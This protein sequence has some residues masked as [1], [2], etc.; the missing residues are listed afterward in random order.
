MSE[1]TYSFFWLVL[2]LCVFFYT[3]FSIYMCLNLKWLNIGNIYLNLFFIHSGNVFCLMHGDHW[4]V[5]WFLIY[6]WD[7]IYHICYTFLFVTFFFFFVF[8]SFSAFCCFNWEFY[9]IPFS[10]LFSLWITL[11]FLNLFSG[12]LEFA[13][14]IYN[15]HKTTFQFF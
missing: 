7:N 8:Y 4:C 9:I 13:I 12:I 14:Y 11:P 5:K 3:L 2:A 6:S 1:I 10:F 15:E